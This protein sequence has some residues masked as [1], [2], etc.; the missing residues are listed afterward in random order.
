MSVTK[1]CGRLVDGGCGTVPVPVLLLPDPEV[2]PDVW[3]VSLGMSS[4]ISCLNEG[5]KCVLLMLR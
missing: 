1:F 5:F 4:N 3:N 2:G